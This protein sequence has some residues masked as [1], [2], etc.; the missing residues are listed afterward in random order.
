MRVTACVVV[1]L[2]ESDAMPALQDIGGGQ[3]SHTRADYS[4]SGLGL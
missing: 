2:E 3:A 4:D 1:L